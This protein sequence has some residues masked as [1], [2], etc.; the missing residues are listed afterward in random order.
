MDLTKTIDRTLTRSET[1]SFIDSIEFRIVHTRDE[2]EKA[3]N[4]VYKEY[5]KRDYTEANSSQLRFSLFNALPQ[6]TTF[7]ATNSSEILATA[8]VMLDSKLGIPMDE[9]YSDKLADIRENKIRICEASMLASNTEL[10]K[11]GTS[12]MLQSKKMFLVFFLF[13]AILDY[14]K[15][16]KNLDYICITINPKHNL[17]Y[18]F[19][20]FKNLGELKTYKY[21]NNAPAIAKYVDLNTIEKECIKQKK[22]GMRRM[23]FQEKTDISQFLPR[24]NFSREDLKYFFVEKSDLFR[25]AS[26]EQLAYIQ[27][28]YKNYDLKSL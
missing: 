16:V 18:D 17:I 19:L 3:Y 7:I 20:M 5:L 10:F 13:K 25:Q 14:V 26:N 9:I 4:L 22:E 11:K 27:S 1:R 21:A 2:L 6:T 28:C 24:F 23:F 15:Y 12:M 8:T